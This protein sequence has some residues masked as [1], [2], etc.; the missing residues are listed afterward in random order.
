VVR[1]AREHLEALVPEAARAFCTVHAEVAEAQAHEAILRLAA[2][3]GADLIIMGV[4]N[5]DAFDVAV[6]GSHT[7]AVVRAAHCPVL[8]VHQD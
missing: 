2:E 8:T 7:Q 4:R 6:F 3:D 5:R 1:D